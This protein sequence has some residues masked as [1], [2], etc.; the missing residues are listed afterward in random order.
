MG[1]N[2]SAGLEGPLYH[3]KLNINGRTYVASRNHNKL[4]SLVEQLKAKGHRIAN[5]FPEVAEMVTM[6]PAQAMETT[7]DALPFYEGFGYSI[8]SVARSML[9]NSAKSVQLEQISQRIDSF[10]KNMFM[11]IGDEDSEQYISKFFWEPLEKE[12]PPVLEEE[13]EE[14]EYDEDV[15]VISGGVQPVLARA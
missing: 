13:E 2:L 5:P 7:L 10:L 1:T 14:V 8:K 11:E 15:R 6:A 9:K 3:L 4:K 12:L